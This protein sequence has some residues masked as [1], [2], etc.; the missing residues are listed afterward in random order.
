MASK[1]QMEMTQLGLW[2]LTPFVVSAV[3][4]WLSPWLLPQYI[5]LDFHQLALVYGGAIVAYLAGAG[6]GATLAPAA[7]KYE[8]FLPG[9][10]ITL[11]AFVAILPSGVFFIAIDAV[12]R[13]LIILLLL[14]YL[15]MRDLR[16]ASAGVLPKWYGRLRIRLTLWASLSIILIA[17]RLLLWGYY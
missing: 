3:A 1:Q 11:V 13:H 2:G 6:A 10:L 12:W 4:L 7:Q 8:S 5:A 16:A 9:Q 17:S 14:F 15:L